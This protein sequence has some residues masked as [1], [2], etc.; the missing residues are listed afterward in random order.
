MCSSFIHG[1]TFIII[2][3]LSLLM[4]HHSFLLR[5][6]RLVAMD[7][8]VLGSKCYQHHLYIVQHCADSEMEL[9]TPLAQYGGYVQTCACRRT[10]SQ[11]AAFKNHQNSCTM[12]KKAF[13][14]ALNKAKAVLAA[15]KA[16]RR[17]ALA[18]SRQQSPTGAESF[19]N[20][21]NGVRYINCQIF[22]CYVTN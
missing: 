11:P 15:K 21:S 18:A 5:L 13:S 4:Q 20:L 10:F 17:Q 19:E 12:S 6:L 22:R 14:D 3:Y 16:K 1:R 7:T 2:I 9:G 8:E